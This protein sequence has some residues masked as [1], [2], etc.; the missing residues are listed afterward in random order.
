MTASQRQG[1]TTLGIFAALGLVWWAMD[2]PPTLDNPH[3]IRKRKKWSSYA[4]TV[5]ADQRRA[6]TFPG[7][8]GWPKRLDPDATLADLLDWLWWYDDRNG[9][10]CQ[11]LADLASGPD[12]DGRQQAIDDAWEWIGELAEIDEF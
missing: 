8:A 7:L 12:P 11:D 6:G 3:P 1:W 9:K 10:Q 5:I 4:N 2:E